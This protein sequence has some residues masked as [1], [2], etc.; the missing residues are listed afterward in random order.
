MLQIFSMYVGNLI[1]MHMQQ[2]V[3]NVQ[4][5]QLFLFMKIGKKKDSSTKLGNY[6]R[7][8]NYKI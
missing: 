7:E 4:H 2:Q 8:E 6:Q 1:K 5:N 3:K